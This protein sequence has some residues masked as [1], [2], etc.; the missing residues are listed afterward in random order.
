MGERPL[1]PPE[2]VTYPFGNGITLLP[3]MK[4]CAPSL[5]IA[6]MAAF[7]VL[8]GPELLIPDMACSGGV[9]EAS[10]IRVS[11]RGSCA[12]KTA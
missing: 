10:R 4:V 6:V 7:R 3:R 12:A 1:P 5:S 2:D 9:H 8:V 11:T